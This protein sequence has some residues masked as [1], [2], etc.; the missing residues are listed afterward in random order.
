MFS[1]PATH[2]VVVSPSR[3]PTFITRS[4]RT[5]CRRQNHLS[6]IKKFRRT[7]PTTAPNYTSNSEPYTYMVALYMASSN[8]LYRL[9]LRFKLRALHF[10]LRDSLL[11]PMNMRSI[12]A[13]LKQPNLPLLL[14]LP[15]SVISL[16]ISHTLPLLVH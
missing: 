14:L 13:S 10:H 15:R 6:A 5:L 16:S 7:F 11:Q 3:H 1:F 12:F 4:S 2:L 9:R 8:L